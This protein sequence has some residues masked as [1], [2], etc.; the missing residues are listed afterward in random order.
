ME[1]RNSVYKKALKFL[2]WVYKS[3]PSK[4]E[5]AML[6]ELIL[7]SSDEWW[8]TEGVSKPSIREAHHAARVFKACGERRILNTRDEIEQFLPRG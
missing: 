8:R 3:N 2:Y 4:A 1:F 7:N 6:R 5:V